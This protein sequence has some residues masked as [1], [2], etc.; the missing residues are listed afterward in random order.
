MKMEKCEQRKKS[1][2]EKQQ[3]KTE[4]NFVF[5]VTL[6]FVNEL[7]RTNRRRWLS[8]HQATYVAAFKRDFESCKQVMDPVWIMG[9]T[10]QR[11]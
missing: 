8:N 9:Q 1:K 7:K 3:Q 5:S 10:E 2:E 11:R 6:T 4:T